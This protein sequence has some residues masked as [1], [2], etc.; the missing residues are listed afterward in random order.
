MSPGERAGL[1]RCPFPRKKMCLSRFSGSQKKIASLSTISNYYRCAVIARRE[2]FAI[3]YDYRGGVSAV[4]RGLPLRHHLCP[5]LT[6][7]C[8]E[9]TETSAEKLLLWTQNARATYLAF[10]VFLSYFGFKVIAA[11]KSCERKS[12]LHNSFHSSSCRGSSLRTGD[13]RSTRRL[14]PAAFPFAWEMGCCFSRPGCPCRCPKKKDT[15]SVLYSFC[16]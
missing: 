15:V 9:M 2:Y 6:Q 5:S 11:T 10:L 12:T 13:R 1:G 8:G 4:A 14:G 3:D 7:T 16:T